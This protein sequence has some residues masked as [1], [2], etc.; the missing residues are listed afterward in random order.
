MQSL[1]SVGRWQALALRPVRSRD[2]GATRTLR[3]C[4]LILTAASVAYLALVAVIPAAR[5]GLP[6]AVK[7]FGCPGSWQSILI[8]VGLI[9]AL[10]VFS[11]RRGGGGS[12]SLPVTIVLGLTAVNCVLSVASY[13]N[14]HDA[15]HPMFVT[16]LMWTLQLLKGSTSQLQ[17]SSGRVCPL[18][19]P[20]ALEVA[21]LSAMGVILFGVASVGMA[22]FEA[23]LDRF[24]ARFAK[25]L[26]VV[27]GVDDESQS[28]VAAV[29]RTL[30][31]G[32]HLVL[33]ADDPERACVVR[34]RGAGARV[35][36]ADLSRPRTLAALPFWHK[37]DRL[38]LLDVDPVTNVDR[39][40]AIGQ[41]MS[42]LGTNR[43]IPLIVRID[44]PWHAAAWRAEQFGGSD[45]RW[46]ADTVGKYEVTARRLLDDVIAEPVNRILVCGTSPL[47]LALC[48]DYA[49]RQLEREFFDDR[50]DRPLPTMTIV[51]DAADEYRRDHEFR[52][53]QSGLPSTEH[54]IDALTEQPTLPALMQQIDA[55][56]ETGPGVTAVMFVD[57]SA[58]LDPTIATRLATRFP[59]LPIYA[60]NPNAGD[61]D[62]REPIFGQLRSYR[63]AMDLPAGQGH[64]AWERAA[65]L[66]HQR[67]V[68][69]VSG[70][71][72][73]SRP[74]AELSDFYRGSNRRQVRNALWIVEQIG[75]H[76]WNLVGGHAEALAPLTSSSDP[77]E[78]LAAMGFDRSTALAM[79]R[80]EHE[81]WSRYYQKAGW[82]PGDR[83]DEHRKTHPKLVDWAEI[84]ANPA[85]LHDALA[86]LATTLAQLRE[87]GYRSRPAWQRFRRIGVVTAQQQHHPWTWTTESGD[88][89]HA[90]AGDW[91]VHDSAGN[92]WSVRDEIFRDSYEHID[93]GH[94]RRTGLVFARPARD[95]ETVDT[96]EGPVTVA[97]G[98]WIVKGE[99]GEQWPVP[100]AQFARRY[101]GPVD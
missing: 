65:K 74:W 100:P 39:L 75:G 21:R 4:L 60:W 99:R 89:M 53:Q 30:E 29:A 57:G 34:S 16:P 91:L 83:R 18:P 81:D 82:R 68:A 19:T 36:P 61:S 45:T 59:D 70:T 42:A 62:D 38:Y 87:L 63:L 43:R 12:S 25:S 33:V 67:Y 86:S 56:R 1:G 35:I 40:R 94:W 95:G 10:C 26:T 41:A 49:Q 2:V 32:S 97:E 22:L 37:T 80:A 79:A 6:P 15:T 51:G 73:A 101:Q 17:L 13:W 77:L 47:T 92:R 66:I 20:V 8:V 64:D 90:A 85:Y 71:S 96:L 27:V 69:A 5:E 11:Y 3:I 48:A 78:R 58:G 7:W 31:P 14:C 46:A 54:C 98:A 44:D 28:V 72:P 50:P 93:N 84:E 9:L 55:D 88:V 23:Q 52:Q 24:R 76:T